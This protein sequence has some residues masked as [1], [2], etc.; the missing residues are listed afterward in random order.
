MVDPAS[1]GAP[2]SV[3]FTWD[4]LDGDTGEISYTINITDNGAQISSTTVNSA[5]MTTVEDLPPCLS[6]MATLVATNTTD[7]NMS[8]GESLRFNTTENGDYVSIA[9]PYMH[10]NVSTH[11]K[12]HAC[13]FNH[14]F[15]HLLF[16][17]SHAKC[18]I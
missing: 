10:V 18:D 12:V 5:N 6:L 15:E 1:D 16:S 3:T 4:P 9:S 11:V 14:V 2:V 13:Y 8:D 17:Y 7:G